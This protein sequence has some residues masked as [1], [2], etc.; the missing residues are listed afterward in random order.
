[1][2]FQFIRTKGADIGR[3]LV[4]TVDCGDFSRGSAE[5]AAL[6]QSWKPNLRLFAETSGK[7]AVIITPHADMDLAVAD[8]VDS[9]FGHSGQKCSAASLVICVGDVYDSPRFRR[10][11]VDAVESLVVGDQTSL[12]TTVGPTIHPVEGKLE[13]ALTRLE[14]GEG[15]LVPPQKLDEEASLWRPGVRMGVQPGS[16][17]H[18]TECF[19]PVL[20]VMYA[21][22]LDEAI[23][24]QNSTDYGLTGGIHTLDPT[25]VDRW[26]GNVEVG[27]AY[28]NR[29][30]TGAIVQRQPFGGWKKSNIGPG[31]KAGGPNYVMQLGRWSPRPTKDLLAAAQQSDEHWW[32]AEFSKEHDPTELFCESNV[33]RYRPLQRVVI[34][35]GHGATTEELARVKLAAARCGVTYDV[36]RL[37]DESDEVFAAGLAGLDVERVRVIGQISDIIQLAANEAGVYLAD[38]AVTANGRLEMLNYLREQAISRT[39]H[40]FGNLVGVD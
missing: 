34:R 31:A 23:A 40:R 7:N 4:T 37:S 12:A 16:W 1:M 18:Q 32:R 15:W 24:I 3:R 33:L 9:A 17:F 21:K 2:P 25:E 39:L 13:R 6:F 20:G 36:S 22:N 27:N 5:T 38:Q 10:Q 30:I 14:P 29:A 19:G 35:Y 28:V 26:V 11:L 8:L